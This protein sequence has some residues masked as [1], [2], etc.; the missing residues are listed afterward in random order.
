[1]TPAVMWLVVA[2][3]AMFVLW[4]FG[5]KPRWMVDYVLLSPMQC[6]G[7]LYLWQPLTSMFLETSGLAFFFT[8]F[9]MW[10]FVPALEQ[11]WGWRRFLFFFLSVGVLSN[12]VGVVLSHYY[13]PRLFGGF[14]EATLAVVVAFGVLW[15]K[16]PVSFF[17]VLPMSARQLALVIVGLAYIQLAIAGDWIMLVVTTVAVAYAMLITSYRFS[18][19]R[20][21]EQWRMARLRR[22]YKV[23]SGGREPTEKKWLN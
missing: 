4:A 7:K 20:W 2:N 15:G 21:F 5:N 19:A 23:L 13:Q 6:F 11:H 1:M 3:A 12:L 10:L 14:N 18:P 22:R 8:I 16:Q 9:A 17:G